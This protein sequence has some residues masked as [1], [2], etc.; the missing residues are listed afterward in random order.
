MPRDQRL[1][2]T[3]SGGSAFICDIPFVRFDPT[4][5]RQLVLTLHA[6]SVR[7]SRF[8]LKNGSLHACTEATPRSRSPLVQGAY[9]NDRAVVVVGCQYHRVQLLSLA[10]R[11]PW[12]L[13]EAVR[14]PA[15]SA[16]LV[17][18]VRSRAAPLLVFRQ[19]DALGA[20]VRSSV[21]PPRGF[22]G[23]EFCQGAAMVP[24]SGAEVSGRSRRLARSQ[25]ASARGAPG[26]HSRGGAFLIS[27]SVGPPPPAWRGRAP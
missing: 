6:C 5:P 16:R 12:V 15:L 9:V 24:F 21:R 4:H 2:P 18:A 25:V 17:R 19:S 7:P 3:A 8:P 14:L 1:Q 27:R 10:E 26:S 13:R 22:F 20:I 11:M 23:I